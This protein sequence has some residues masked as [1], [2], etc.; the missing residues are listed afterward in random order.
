MDVWAVIRKTRRIFWKYRRL[1]YLAGG[2]LLAV[3]A[4][5]YFRSFF[6]SGVDWYDAFLFKGQDQ[7][8]VTY[9]G[10]DS[11]GTVAISVNRK[12]AGEIDI[13]YDLPY[14]KLKSYKIQLSAEVDFWRLL[15]ITDQNGETVFD[16][17]YQ[18]GNSF[19][20]T[21]SGMPAAGDIPAIQS[22][23]NPYSPF[24]PNYRRMVGIAT[25]E[26]D[27]LWG[28]WWQLAIGLLLIA[29]VVVDVRTP[30]I[31][32]RLRKY[33]TGDGPQ[34]ADV[35]ELAQAAVRLVVI[36]VAMGFLLSAI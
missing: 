23:E 8:T 34:R 12:N 18:T 5:F 1:F 20:Y 31:S 27:R 16:G 29:L 24:H 15:T 30:K 6:S 25:G 36:L 33:L 9:I 13:A 4:V 32:S 3:C 22:G 7:S 26:Y 14:N 21:L 35:Y 2:I 19:L 10:Q 28:S 11:Y 17:K